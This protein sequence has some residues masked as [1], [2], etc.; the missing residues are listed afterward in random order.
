MPARSSPRP[1]KK[2]STSTSSR[3]AHFTQAIQKPRVSP[4]RCPGFS[5]ARKN[6]INHE[7][8]EEHEGWGKKKGCRAGYLL[9]VRYALWV[10]GRNYSVRRRGWRIAR[11]TSSPPYIWVPSWASCSSWLT[12]FLFVQVKRKGGASWGG[13]SLGWTWFVLLV[14]VTFIRRR[15]CGWIRF[16]SR[17]KWSRRWSFLHRIASRRRWHPW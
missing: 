6:Q 4:T 13:A 8:H 2:W 12:R 1:A 5:F 15:R 9:P 7:E 16:P 11:A 17:V 3:T 10:G 14:Y